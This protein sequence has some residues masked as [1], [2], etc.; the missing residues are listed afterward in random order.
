M[1]KIQLKIIPSVNTKDII[2]FILVN[3][4]PD[5]EILTD[6]WT[7]CWNKSF[8]TFQKEMQHIGTL[9]GQIIEETEGII[10]LVIVAELKFNGWIKKFVET[11]E[12]KKIFIFYLLIINNSMA[13][14]YKVV[15]HEHGTVHAFIEDKVRAYNGNSSNSD[16]YLMQVF[17][18][19]NLSNSKV[20]DMIVVKPADLKKY[21]ADSAFYPK[22]TVVE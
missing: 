17:K 19:G 21:I 15:T 10:A 8:S 14:V 6:E 22:D 16:L 12:I 20:D 5:V 3:T 9:S 4:N 18:V 7:T 13:K 2:R 1:K 11:Q